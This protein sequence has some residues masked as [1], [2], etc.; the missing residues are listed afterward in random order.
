MRAFWECFTAAQLWPLLGSP[1]RKDELMK[2]KEKAESHA[3]NFFIHLIIPVWIQNK[4]TKA[5]AKQTKA[6]WHFPSC[7]TDVKEFCNHQAR[8]LLQQKNSKNKLLKKGF[9]PSLSPSDYGKRLTWNLLN[10]LVSL[11]KLSQESELPVDVAYSS[12]LKWLDAGKCLRKDSQLVYHF[13]TL[14]LSLF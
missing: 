2:R 9:Y 6:V 5:T 7:I 1:W 3:D 11:C 8:I 4:Q 14:S 10:H 13:L 12:A